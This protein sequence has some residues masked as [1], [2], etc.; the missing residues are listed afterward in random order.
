MLNVGTMVGIRTIALLSGDILPNYLVMLQ[1][2][3]TIHIHHTAET[4]LHGFCYYHCVVTIRFRNVCRYTSLK[5][6]DLRD[7]S[8]LS[9]LLTMSMM[10]F[11]WTYKIYRS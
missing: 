10:M 8:S 7:F 6:I 2:N 5:V 4:L 11:F 3:Q 9:L 1:G